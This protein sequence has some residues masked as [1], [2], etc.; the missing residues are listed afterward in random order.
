MAADQRD[1]NA[2]GGSYRWLA[3]VV[4]GRLLGLAGAYAE[5]LAAATTV[6]GKLRTLRRVPRALR[7][8]DLGAR[9]L[10]MACLVLL[11]VLVG[12]TWLFAAVPGWSAIAWTT[13]GQHFT[14]PRAAFH[15]SLVGWAFSAALILAAAS[16]WSLAA[17]L[18]AGCVQLF[19]IVFIGFAGG[20][21][22]ML[23][24]P[25]WLLPVLAATSP[26]IARSRAGRVAGTVL[27]CAL[28][29]WHTYLFTPLS[30]QGRP[31]AWGWLLAL[32]A[33]SVP[34][35]LALPARLGMG[36]SFV[37]ALGVNAGVLLG[38]LAAG[39]PAVTRG[40]VIPT[41]FFVG[42]FSVMWFALGGELVSGAVS[43]T[44]ASIEIVTAAV[45]PQV[46]PFLVLVL[47]LVEVAVAPWLLDR[48]STADAFTLS[49]HRW[50]ALA[51]TVSGLVLAARR[52]LTSG[53]TRALLAVW[54]FGLAALRSYFSGVVDV[55]AYAN[56]QELKGLALTLFTF[57][58][59]MQVVRLLINKEDAGGGSAEGRLF[60]QLGALAFLATGTQ[61]GFAINDTHV[62]KEAAAYQFA[63]AT[64]LFLPLLLA[65]LA[66]EQ[67]WLL[68]PPRS[69]L[70]RGFL[71]GFAAA[72]VIQLARIAT[73]GPGGWSLAGHLGAVALAD[74]VKAV[75]I[76]LLIVAGRALGRVAAPAVAV[77][78]ALG[79][80]AGYAQNLTV[81][82][83]D[84]AGKMLL[85]LTVSSSA[86][87]Q[88]LSTLVAGY[89]RTAPALPAADHYQFFVAS[90][91]PAAIMGAAI[92]RGVS[93][94]R[95]GVGA[96]GTL[97][98]LAVSL[99]FAWALYSHPLFL[100]QSREPLPFYVVVTDASAL[101]PLLLSLLG[102]VAWSYVT[103]WRPERR[104][105]PRPATAHVSVDT[106]T[107]LIGAAAMV[108]PIVTLGALGLA[109]AL[110]APAPMLEYRDPEARFTLDYPRGWH[111][112]RRPGGETVFYRDDSTHG[113]LVML[114][115]GI[116]L[117]GY[118]SAPQL[119]QALDR[120][121]R[122]VYPDARVT[123]SPGV[124]RVANGR[125][126]QAIEMAVA[127]TAPGRGRLRSQSTVTL[128]ATRDASRFS[129]VTYQVAEP[130][131]RSLEAML[132]RV[133]RSYR[134]AEPP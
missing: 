19:A 97:A 108:A 12:A 46:L 55:A 90:L 37:L 54:V 129:Y 106:A 91:L 20:K 25:S 113:V 98:G 65:L 11:T 69:L 50:L 72:F 117:P 21:A 85:L 89:V 128:I 58:M 105:P 63:G 64:A 56:A 134:A 13:G 74:A 86:L 109:L 126:I 6:S 27:L 130:A 62:M 116:A 118:V 18:P 7:S 66:K 70:V 101:A 124:P 40:M 120:T 76:A 122:S 42:L 107:R 4:V 41:S 77:A 103:V 104:V 71:T 83:L 93:D 121:I 60:L 16:Q 35:L 78:C 31:P 61:F 95:P 9:T 32:F 47:C 92:A 125:S 102:F 110:R 132:A 10:A 81:L 112:E 133:R 29:T 75:C 28:A 48:L 52:R 68:A 82:M 3:S 34:G 57:A 1:A 127:W 26:A 14:L 15:L 23:T 114:H 59:A 84:A 79:F 43:A 99:G 80:A 53:W 5:V 36:R 38:A 94:R 49:I 131:P 111:V 45:R 22:Y 96:L 100:I 88:A 8:L 123:A 51:L 39:E 24:A 115:P 2:S 17:L 73:Y 44:N 87:N 30:A 119:V 33:V 67:R